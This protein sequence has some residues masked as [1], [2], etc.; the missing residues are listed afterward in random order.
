[1]EACNK[2]LQELEAKMA[3]VQDTRGKLAKK[4]LFPLIEKEKALC[5]EMKKINMQKTQVQLEFIRLFKMVYPIIYEVH[6]QLDDSDGYCDDP[7]YYF[8]DEGVAREKYDTER[9]WRKRQNI[10]INFYTRSTSND[11]RTKQLIL[12]FM[13]EKNMTEQL[14]NP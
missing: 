11:G 5:R 3:N 7:R 9:E 14:I 10:P 2:S 12:R 13:L 4:E 8:V 6:V 1:M